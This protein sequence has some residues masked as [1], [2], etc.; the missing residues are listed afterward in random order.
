MVGEECE[1][2]WG[3]GGEGGRWCGDGWRVV[4]VVVVVVVVGGGGVMDKRLTGP[5]AW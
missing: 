4:V 2:G 5:R 3:M 1:V